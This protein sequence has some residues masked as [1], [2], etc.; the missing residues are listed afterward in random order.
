MVVSAQSPGSS[1]PQTVLAVRK[2]ACDL[3]SLY[4]GRII[5]IRIIMCESVAIKL[6]ETKLSAHPYISILILTNKIGGAA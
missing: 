2:Q 6:V 1:H 4:G 5:F 3:V